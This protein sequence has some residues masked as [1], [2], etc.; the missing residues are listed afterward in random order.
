[1]APNVSAQEPKT[2]RLGRHFG[3]FEVF[4][5]QDLRPGCTFTLGN[6]GQ[7]PVNVTSISAH[8]C[9]VLTETGHFTTQVS[10]ELPCPLLSS[11]THHA[12]NRLCW[13]IAGM[14]GELDDKVAVL[15][16]VSWQRDC[17]DTC[18]MYCSWTESWMIIY[19]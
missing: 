10:W 9:S 14:E 19:D 13:D 2:H 15:H 16:G 11:E 1:M 4:R 12:T 17:D 8:F 6:N 3:K 5:T 18:R 7:G